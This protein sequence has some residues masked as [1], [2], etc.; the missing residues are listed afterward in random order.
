MK[1]AALLTTLLLTTVLAACSAEQ[2]RTLAPQ[3]APASVDPSIPALT[4]TA[5]RMTASEKL[6]YDRSTAVD[7]A[8]LK[9]GN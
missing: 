9:T 5:H 4:I 7:V 8:A 3:A 6:A 2:S 1:V